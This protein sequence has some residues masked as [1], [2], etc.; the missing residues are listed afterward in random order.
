M[1]EMKAETSLEPIDSEASDIGN[2]DPF[3]L[4]LL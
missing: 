2:L 1:R 3:V 4:E